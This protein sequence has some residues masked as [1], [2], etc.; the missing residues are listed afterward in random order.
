MMLLGLLLSQAVAAPPFEWGF[1]SYAWGAHVAPALLAAEECSHVLYGAWSCS[2]AVE[3][4][5]AEV[6]YLANEEGRLEAIAAQAWG[7]GSCMAI[8]DRLVLSWGSGEEREL[9]ARSVRI[10]RAGDRVAVWQYNPA[11]R[12]C[13]LT[14]ER[15]G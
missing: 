4:I 10:W 9:I 2:D 1:K 11:D 12:M 3:G 14:I 5:A 8:E 6:A 15:E 13:I 7:A